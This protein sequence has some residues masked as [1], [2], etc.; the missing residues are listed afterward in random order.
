M[1]QDPGGRS[2]ATCLRNAAA[3][4]ALGGVL[5]GY[6]AG[7][8]G[9]AL[10]FIARSFGWDSPFRRSLIISIVLLGAAAGAVLGG[11]LADRLGRRNQILLASV[12]FV[13]AIAGCVWAPG[14][15][16]LLVSRFVLGIAIGSVSVGVPLYISEIAPP[17]RRGGLVSA[18]Q[19]A[20][21]IGILAGQVVSYLLASSGS[22]RL[23]IGLALVPAVLLG[24]GMRGQ[25]ESPV[26]LARH[27]QL[28]AARAILAR[29]RSDP[30]EVESELDQIVRTAGAARAHW[31]ALL[32]PAV[33][34]SLVVGMG[35][36]VVAQVTGVN[37]VIYYAPTLL[38]SAGLGQHA[39][40]LGAVMIGLINVLTTVVAIRVLD[41]VGRR[42]LLLGGTAT[43]AVALFAMAVL[44]AGQP[45]ALSST[46]AILAIA[47][48][49]VYIGA[50]AIGL[51][52]IFWLLIAEIYPA[53]LR[54]VAASSAAVV[55]WLANFAVTVSYLSIL[56]SIGRTS[57]YA[58]L[59]ILTIVAVAFIYTQV[60]ETK[61]RSLSEIEDDLA[62]RVEIPVP[63]YL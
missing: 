45:P 23:M 5:F 47:A 39:A 22:W 28:D 48:L 34:P 63:E 21:T 31:R 29:V 27:G 46:R 49:C 61:G 6:D 58:L 50:F 9:G 4:A 26:W 40:I 59:T 38:S 10:P 14:A 44:F 60:P 2:Q 11:R 36:A 19:L 17:A 32:S 33:R 43:M 53:R 35:L 51:G 7:V 8:A 54:G 24:V 13:A 62:G 37:T 20:V 18:N 52:P 42:V 16:V 12:T 57:T 55:N 30:N 1:R 15:G 25:P 3:L 41:V 56:A